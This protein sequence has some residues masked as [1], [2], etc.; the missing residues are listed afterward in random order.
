M[1]KPLLLAFLL[2]FTF[3]A[4]AQ[5]TE[6]NNHNYYNYYV[7]PTSMKGDMVGPINKLKSRKLG[8]GWLRWNDITPI[9]VEEMTKAGYDQ[10][11]TNKLF[12]IDSA[13]YVLLAALSMR[14]PMVGI[15][16]SEGH[17]AFPGASDRQPGHQLMGDGKYDYVQM[18][19]TSANRTELIRIRKLPANLVALQ[20]NWYWYQYT[21]NPS[22]NKYLLTREDIIRVLREDIQEKLATAPKPSKQ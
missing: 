11:Y 18:V 15:L 16:Y 21:D 1:K 4:L 20:E 6:I 19:S 5:R 22:D 14:M 10:V 13:Q 12:R 9:L 3:P 17:A 8:T 2:A 7:G